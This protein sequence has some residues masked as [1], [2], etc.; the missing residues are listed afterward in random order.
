MAGKSVDV[1]IKHLGVLQSR[2]IRAGDW[3]AYDIYYRVLR[4]RKKRWVETT[5][6]LVPDRRTGLLKSISAH[7]ANVVGSR[8]IAMA[9][10]GSPRA[11]I[12]NAWGPIML[13]FTL[14]REPIGFCF[15][16]RLTESVM[17]LDDIGFLT[18]EME[19]QHIGQALDQ[20]K[21]RGRERGASRIIIMT[22]DEELGK[23]LVES[24]FSLQ[25]KDDILFCDLP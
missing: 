10:S 15:L 1:Q 25:F 23:L 6:V 9:Q 12:Q 14:D 2:P 11:L 7:I 19:Q 22:E 17:Q 20:V 16:S 5:G 8:L 24:G 13:Q 21:K 18:P 3:V 4:R